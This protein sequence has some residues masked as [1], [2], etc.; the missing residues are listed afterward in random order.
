MGGLNFDDYGRVFVLDKEAVRKGFYEHLIDRAA[1][2][3][4]R[5]GELE[6]EA[7]QKAERAA[8]HRVRAKALREAACDYE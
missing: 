2:D 7:Q 1:Q 4:E 5:A 6:E 8:K 3:E